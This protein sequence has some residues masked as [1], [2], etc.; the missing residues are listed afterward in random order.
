VRATAYGRT[1]ATL[2]AYE[3]AGDRWRVADGPRTAYVGRAGIA[4]AG[5]KREADGRTPSGAYRFDFMFGV[6]PDPGVRFPFR[7]VTGANIVWDDDPESPRYNQWVDTTTADAGVNPEP[8]YVRPQYDLGAVIAYNTPRTPGL[9]SAIFLHVSA[10][11]ATAGCVA[12][13]SAQLRQLLLWLDPAQSP[14]IVLVVRG[15]A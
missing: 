7:R 14:V 11:R 5:E 4:P 15:G 2:T 10:D 3:R 8:M 6:D 12:L 13:P 9:G 1:S